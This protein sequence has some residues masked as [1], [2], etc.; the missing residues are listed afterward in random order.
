MQYKACL[1]LIS[2]IDS[3]TSGSITYKA[4]SGKAIGKL[5]TVNVTPNRETVTEYGDDGVAEQVSYFKDGDITLGTTFLPRACE[6]IMFGSHASTETVGT[7]QSAAEIPVLT[8]KEED[9]GDYTGF[10]FVW[11]E[12][13]NGV[14]VYHL[15]WIYKVKWEM[16]ADDF[17]TKGQTISFKKPSI[18]GKIAALANGDWRVRKEYT[19]ADAAMEALRTMA[20]M[21]AA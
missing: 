13:Q 20:K 19:T 4:N 21:P 3:E 17:E 9:D 5:M 10:G 1:P 6:P 7:G 8:D 11:A 14:K 16:P 18:K 12:L 15:M 2:E